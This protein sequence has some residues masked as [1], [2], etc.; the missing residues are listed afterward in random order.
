VRLDK[1]GAEL[2]TLSIDVTHHLM[3]HHH[4]LLRELGA[5]DTAHL[6][7]MIPGQKVLVAGVRASTQTPPIPSGKRVI[8]T[9]LEDGSGLVDIAFFEDSH[10]ACV[11]AHTVGAMAQ[12]APG[13]PTAMP[14]RR[15]VAAVAAVTAARA[16][17]S[18]PGAAKGLGENVDRVEDIL[19][20]LRAPAVQA[21]EVRRWHAPSTACSAAFCP[22]GPACAGN[23]MTTQRPSAR[24]RSASSF[25]D[26][27]TRCDVGGE[28]GA[29]L[30][31]LACAWPQLPS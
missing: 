3:E 27:V 29:Q 25:T 10:Q 6:R 31:G 20:G 13:R 26:C 19:G 17:E 30:R 15:R 7:S 4:R 1:L 5:T 11:P 12:R 21:R 28:S 16:C 2:E 24:K 22:P 9:T 8:F 14:K 23:S 18:H